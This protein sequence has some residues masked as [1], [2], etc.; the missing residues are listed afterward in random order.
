MTY[1]LYHSE[2]NFAKYYLT[3]P[4]FSQIRQRIKSSQIIVTGPLAVLYQYRGL[5]LMSAA[6]LLLLQHSYSLGYRLE[7]A[8]AVSPIN[9]YAMS[10]YG[11]IPLPRISLSFPEILWK[12]EKPWAPVTFTSKIPDSD[13]LCLCLYAVIEEVEKKSNKS[14]HHQKSSL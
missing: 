7:V 12:N 13:N 8:W 14:P 5:N 9:A 11:F 1:L 6:H 10:R 2:L 4:S 3:D